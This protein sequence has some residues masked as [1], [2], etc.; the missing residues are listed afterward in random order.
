MWKKTSVSLNAVEQR[1]DTP[2]KKQLSSRHNSVGKKGRRREGLGKVAGT[3]SFVPEGGG[4]GSEMK[5]GKKA[6]PVWKVVAVMAPKVLDEQPHFLSQRRGVSSAAVAF[7]IWPVP[8]PG[9]AFQLMALQ[10]ERQQK[11]HLDLY[12]CNNHTASEMCFCCSL[13]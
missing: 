1:T 9:A 3:T 8:S 13:F 10:L 7:R 4:E 6:S 11:L 2:A 5:R 12:S